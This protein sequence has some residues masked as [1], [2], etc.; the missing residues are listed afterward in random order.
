[1]DDVRRHVAVVDDEPHVFATTVGENLRLA[2]PDADD[3]A[4]DAPSSAPASARGSPSFP[5]AWTPGSAP[6]AAGSPAVSGPGWRRPR[7]A[8]RPPVVLLDEPMAHL[9]H[10]TAT[11]VLDDVLSATDGRTSSW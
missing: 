4:L 6:V 3:A 11:A 10:A 1:M 7:R 5:R 9:D 2:G 8:G